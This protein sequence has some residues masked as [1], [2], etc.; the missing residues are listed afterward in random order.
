MRGY[1]LVFAALLFLNGELAKADTA[2]EQT[3]VRFATSGGLVPGEGGRFVDGPIETIEGHL[4]VPAG[5]GPFP[6]VVLAHGCGG[7]K[8]QQTPF[9]ATRLVGAG[10]AVFSVDSFRPRGLPGPP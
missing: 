1:F 4:Y 6:A 5:D 2:P 9:W 7:Y 8:D 10:Y 3:I